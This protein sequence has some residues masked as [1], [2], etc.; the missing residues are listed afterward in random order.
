MTL[1]PSCRPL[2][3]LLIIPLCGNPLQFKLKL[4]SSYSN[5]SRR[6]AVSS[7]LNPNLPDQK[8]VHMTSVASHVDAFSEFDIIGLTEA[9]LGDSVLMRMR[10]IAFLRQLMDI[11]KIHKPLHIYGSLDPVCTP[12]YFL[13]GAD[14]F[15]GLSWLRFAYRDE[16]AVYH[17][18]RVPLDFDPSV[19]ED[20]GR[21]RSYM[22]NL[23]YLVSELTPD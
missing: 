9:E 7:S 15:D 10:N 14:I 18:N 12:L 22:A 8:F 21:M 16:L 17:R 23:H 19:S 5:N 11:Q 13:A 20:V 1:I 4:R 6:L 3:P 2:P